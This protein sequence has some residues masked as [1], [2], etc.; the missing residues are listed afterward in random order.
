MAV[1]ENEPPNTGNHLAPWA[2]APLGIPGGESVESFQEEAGRLS[3][4]LTDDTD[5]VTDDGQEAWSKGAAPMPMT[6]GQLLRYRGMGDV[7]TVS[8]ANVES[9]CHPLINRV[10]AEHGST[11]RH[12]SLARAA[13]WNALRPG[14]PGSP[15]GT[16]PGCPKGTPRPPLGDYLGLYRLSKRGRRNSFLEQHKDVFQQDDQPLGRTALVQHTIDTE[17]AVP[18]KQPPRREP[19]FLRGQAE[20]EVQKMLDEG[21]ITPSISPWASPTVLVK[22]KDGTIRFCV[23]YRR[24]NDVTKKDAYP[25]PRIED[26][27]SRLG[28]ASWYSTLDL[29]SGY[30]QI[31][32]APQDR[33]KTAFCTP[34]GLW[35][36]VVMPFGLVN[37]PATF[38]RLMEKVLCPVLGR[39]ALVYLDDVYSLFGRS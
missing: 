20:A 14:K 30:W 28:G 15:L 23:D 31:E 3:G 6:A 24:L 13:L 21:I 27:L 8:A 26:N 32:V 2:A 34:G 12:L 35:E 4:L 36:F 22:K 29:H 9:G 19:I 38:E 7:E 16:H 11:L 33:E 25:L 17:G 10:G 1:A 37:A 39:C 5:E 18:I